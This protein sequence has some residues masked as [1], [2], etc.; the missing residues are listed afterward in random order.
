LNLTI[1]FLN[2]GIKQFLN[3]LISYDEY[4]EFF[5]EPAIKNWNHFVNR[6]TKYKSILNLSSYQSILKELDN[7]VTSLNPIIIKLGSLNNVNIIRENEK[8]FYDSLENI[9][10]LINILIKM[11]G[12][13]YIGQ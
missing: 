13:I 12:D 6:Y 3:D 11:K 8:Q 1:Y 7:I 4:R 10:Y 2:N 5:I 9:K